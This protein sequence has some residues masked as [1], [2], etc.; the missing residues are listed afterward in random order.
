MS[1]AQW[2]RVTDETAEDANRGW[3][4]FLLLN[5]VAGAIVTM[6]MI[7]WTLTTA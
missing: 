6:L 2:W 7:G 3:K 4:R 1:T 5:F